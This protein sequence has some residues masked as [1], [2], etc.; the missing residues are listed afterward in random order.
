[1]THEPECP[2][3]PDRPLLFSG[4]G[5]LIGICICP[6][7]HSAY[8]RGRHDAA[9]DVRALI[10]VDFN[11][12]IDQGKVWQEDAITAARGDGGQP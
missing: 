11:P 6:V 2:E 7:L 10:P 4:R 5:V 9:F 3:H 12:A 8:R 1:M